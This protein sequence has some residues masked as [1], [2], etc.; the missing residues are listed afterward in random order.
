[1]V[2]TVSPRHQLGVQMAIQGARLAV[3]RRLA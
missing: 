1:M 2:I 3:M